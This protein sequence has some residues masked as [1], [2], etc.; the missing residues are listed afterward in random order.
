MIIARAD[1]YARIPDR[2]RV[3]ELMRETQLRARE[4]P[5]CVY[6]VFAETL[7]DPGH[8][9][10]L[11][12]WRDPKSLDGHYRSDAF[13]AYQTAIGPHLVRT[14]EMQVLEVSAAAI[15]VDHSPIEPQQDA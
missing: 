8:F 14:S 7:D 6:F 12:Q 9:V 10:F 15:P 2:D 5:G 11:Q 3:L 1:I 13:A 4:Q